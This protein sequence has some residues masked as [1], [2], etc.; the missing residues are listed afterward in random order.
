MSDVVVAAVVKVSAVGIARAVSLG[1]GGTGVATEE[2]EELVNKRVVVV[3]V[4]EN[5]G[6]G[7]NEASVNVGSGGS[8]AVRV[9]GGEGSGGGGRDGREG[10]VRVVAEEASVA[11]TSSA[12]ASTEELF[13]AVALGFTFFGIFEL[14]GRT[15]ES[16]T[17]ERVG[18]SQSTSAERTERVEAESKRV[19]GSL[20]LEERVV[21][22]VDATGSFTAS[23]FARL[24]G[25]LTGRAVGR[26]V[27]T[28]SFTDPT[29]REGRDGDV[30][31]GIDGFAGLVGFV[32]FATVLVSG[33]RLGVS[34]ASSA[35]AV[36][37]ALVSELLGAADTDVGGTSG[38]AF[39][40]LAEDG[41]VVGVLLASE[42]L[43]VGTV[44]QEKRLS[45]VLALGGG[46]NR[47]GG[48]DENCDSHHVANTEG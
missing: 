48:K 34:D 21:E 14:L 24:G 22:A 8:E 28:G 42:A 7:I 5:A 38:S 37:G 25:V 9:E 26:W 45:A 23:T 39:S 3:V 29:G 6:K 41:A 40:L 33:G 20:S 31:G 16:E 27:G 19:D 4:T 15:T 17:G 43:T 12:Q 1:G 10:G 36:H 13:L 32:P 18:N 46:G 47:E 30:V 11:E 2:V 35:S 44:G